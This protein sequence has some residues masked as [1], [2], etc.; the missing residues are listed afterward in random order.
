M[1]D[2]AIGCDLRQI[3]APQV[4]TAFSVQSAGTMLLFS[5]LLAHVVHALT[6]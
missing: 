5:Q 3:Q 4:A 1:P 6:A 2:R